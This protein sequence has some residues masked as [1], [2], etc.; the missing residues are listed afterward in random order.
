MSPPNLLPGET[1]GQNG[2]VIDDGAGSP[3]RQLMIFRWETRLTSPPFW[4]PRCFVLP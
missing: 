3:D 2:T 4:S 1:Q